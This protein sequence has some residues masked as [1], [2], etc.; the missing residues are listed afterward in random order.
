M[1]KR[2]RWKPVIQREVLYDILIQY[3]TPIK[4]RRLNKMSFNWTYIHIRTGKYLS[5]TFQIHNGQK[6][7]GTLSPF[8]FKFASEYAI[9][10]IQETHEGME[11]NGSHQ[12]LDYADYVNFII[13]NSYGLR[14]VVCFNSELLL[15]LWIC[16]DILQDSLDE[17]SARRKASTYTGEHNTERRGQTFIIW[18]G[19]EPTIPVSKRPRLTR[20][21]ARQLRY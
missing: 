15:K 21:I 3:G 19:F 6:Q 16:S 9:R 17:L 20:Q 11:L 1:R 10:E 13:I 14:V 18:A 5:N 12:L 7:V 2:W 4:L 8:L